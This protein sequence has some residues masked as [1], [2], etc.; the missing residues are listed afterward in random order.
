[1]AGDADAGHP[2]PERPLRGGELNAA[3]TSAVVG[4]HTEF[5]GRGP[6]SASTFHHGVHVVTVL[7]GMLTR[8]EQ[9]LAAG[10]HADEVRAMRLLTRDAM[11]D[12]LTAAI[13]RLTQR[14]VIAAV[15][16]HDARSDATAE[17]YVLDRPL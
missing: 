17:V 3:I 7:R 14:R 8:A 15:G 5:L 2:V 12:E 10:R 6:R 13:E 11:V 9:V 4:V 16:G 1:M